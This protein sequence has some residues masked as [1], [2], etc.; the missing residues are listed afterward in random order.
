MSVPNARTAYE[1]FMVAITQKDEAT[2]D[3][4]LHPD[5]EEVYPQSGE[6]TIGPKNLKGIVLGVPG[7]LED[8][9]GRHVVGAEDRWAMTPTFTLVH[10]D[11]SGDLFTGVQRARYPDGSD[12]WVIQIVTMRDARVWRVESYFAPVFEPAAWRAPF[13]TVDQTT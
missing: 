4:V 12:W 7:G 10:I 1:R 8:L 3:E 6:R 2:L 13:V 9:G 11:G 5:F